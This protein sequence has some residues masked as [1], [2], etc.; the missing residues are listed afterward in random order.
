MTEWWVIVVLLW[1]SSFVSADMWKHEEQCK[2]W[3]QKHL[4]AKVNAQCQKTTQPWQ[5]EL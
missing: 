4:P 5:Q 3:I 1:N 2:A